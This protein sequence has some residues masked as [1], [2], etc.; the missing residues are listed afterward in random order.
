[1]E[2]INIFPTHIHKFKYEHHV[3]GKAGWMS[4]LNNPDNFTNT[5]PNKTLHFTTPNLLVEPVF[6]DLVN[7]FKDCL[8]QTMADLGYIPSAQLTSVWAT[9]HVDTGF[10]PRHFHGNTFLAGVYYMSGGEKQSGTRWYNPNNLYNIIIPARDNTRRL[11]RSPSW[12]HAF[13]EGTLIIFPGWLEHNTEVNNIE[14]TQGERFIIGFNSMPLGKTNQ[15][16]FDRFCYHQVQPE[17]MISHYSQ[18]G[19][20]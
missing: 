16:E 14:N 10:H 9:K 4:Y 11:K 13:E 7:W 5:R 18:I 12:Y 1:M 6:S 19:K 15:D 17:D 2:P 20:P 8:S 3:A